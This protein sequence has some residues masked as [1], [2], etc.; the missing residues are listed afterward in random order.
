MPS[1]KHFINIYY[2]IYDEK[3][4][5]VGHLGFGGHLELPNDVNLASS[6]FQ[7]RIRIPTYFCKNIFY[8]RYFTVVLGSCRTIAN[9]KLCPVKMLL[10][11]AKSGEQDKKR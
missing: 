6:R 9:Q 1:F 3:P 7:I 4:Y 11:K 2:K 8:R 5:F 10:N